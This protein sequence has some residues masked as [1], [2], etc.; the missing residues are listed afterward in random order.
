MITVLW[1]QEGG[2]N[3]AFAPGDYGSKKETPRYVEEGILRGSERYSTL[4]PTSCGPD[5]SLKG[6]QWLAQRGWGGSTWGRARH[7]L[8]S[9]EDLL[10]GTGGSRRETVLR[11]G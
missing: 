7:D 10:A 6:C 1:K 11:P 2:R 8:C 4:P 9:L 3:A 5:Q